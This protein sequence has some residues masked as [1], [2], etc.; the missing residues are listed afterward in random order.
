ML[1]DEYVDIEVPAGCARGLRVDDVLVFKGLP[2]ALAPIAER[3]FQPPVPMARWAGRFDATRE[4]F[5]APQPQSRV[6]KVTGENSGPQ[7]EDCPNLTIYTPAADG[8]RRPVL[9]W[10]H[11]GAHTTGGGSLAWHAGHVLARAGD[12]VV[13]CPNFRL[14]AL[15]FLYLPGISEGNLGL[16]D[17]VAAL[18]WIRENIHAL[19]GDPG[20]ITIAG[21]SSGA[22][23]VAHLTA[24][25][26][27]AGLFRRAIIQSAPLGRPER[28]P[29]EAAEQGEQFRKHL[30]GGGEGGDLRSVPVDAL[31]RA[32]AAYAQALPPAPLGATNLPFMPVVDGRAVPS[33]GAVAHGA[34]CDLIIG[35]TREEMATF[36]AG[37]ERLAHLTRD[38]ALGS[39]RHFTDHA[40]RV[41]RHYG[42]YRASTSPR[43]ILADMLTAR[44]FGIP[45]L[46]LARRYADA[47]HS[48]YAYRFDW[49]SPAGFGACHCLDI[50][51]VFN[52]LDVWARSPMLLGVDREAFR[53]LAA[54]VQGAWAAF[55]R[56]GDPNQSGDMPEWPAYS[57]A[58]PSVMR[59]A[60]MVEA[61]PLPCLAPG[62]AFNR[63]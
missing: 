46:E 53:G 18:E 20:N 44:I 49:Q 61:G 43:A 25:P 3:R 22:S 51:F 31:L 39:M 15:G 37:D 41:Y 58:M 45:S 28:P 9:V 36:H 12:L 2:Y 30:M 47:G 4:P 59:L 1:Q 32:Q 60:S 50:P 26:Q 21:Q 23:C 63:A 16:L 62:D 57:A 19:G 5:I 48:V 54:K 14:G 10:L 29:E 42:R 13:V 7:S 27:A 56:H 34:G 55:A 6:S 17:Q 8:Q 38:D 33:L 11:G 35:F 52:N 40:E 24:M